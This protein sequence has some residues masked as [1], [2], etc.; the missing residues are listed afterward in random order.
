[1]TNL[2]RR[3]VELGDLER[4]VLLQLDGSRD[5]DAVLG[6]VVGQVVSGDFDLS[7]E[8]KPVRDP[9]V[10]RDALEGGIETAIRNLVSFALLAG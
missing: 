10:L 8:G 2:R 7:L 4:A 9:V 6:A 1:V 3:G 5:L